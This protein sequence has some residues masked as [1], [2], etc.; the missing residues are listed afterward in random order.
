MRVD[1]AQNELGREALFLGRPEVDSPGDAVLF[2]VV[3][4]D[5]LN[6]DWG[7]GRRGF[8]SDH[9]VLLMQYLGPCGI[10]LQLPLNIHQQDLWILWDDLAESHGSLP[11]MTFG[12]TIA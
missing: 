8:G 1:C 5:V 3:L 7:L 9:W 2:D 6:D 10:S 12:D 11:R 4:F